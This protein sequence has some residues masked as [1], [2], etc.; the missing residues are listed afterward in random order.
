M[1]TSSRFGTGDCLRIL[2]LKVACRL[3]T[4]PF[5]LEHNMTYNFFAKN[6][7]SKTGCASLDI[8]LHPVIEMLGCAVAPTLDQRARSLAGSWI[9]SGRSGGGDSPGKAR[10]LIH[11][12]LF[13][14]IADARAFGALC[15]KLPLGERRG[16]RDSEEQ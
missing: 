2:W 3:P 5:D 16:Y 12:I 6:A 1:G 9:K 11:D 4:L 15:V 7:A 14:T 13:S 10:G 8:A